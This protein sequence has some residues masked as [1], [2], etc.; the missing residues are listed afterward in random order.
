MVFGLG[1][2]SLVSSTQVEMVADGPNHQ[3][4]KPVTTAFPVQFHGFEGRP[5]PLFGRLKK[6]LKTTVRRTDGRTL[7]EG[8]CERWLRRVR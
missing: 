8:V 2:R 1:G 3:A 4:S 5:S 6:A 7:Q